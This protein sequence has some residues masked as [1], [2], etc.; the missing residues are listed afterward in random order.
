MGKTINR[1]TKI[2]LSVVMMFSV[3]HLPA[4][5]PTSVYATTDETPETTTI[6][7]ETTVEEQ[8]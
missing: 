3:L 4:L 2:V 1:F 7:T 8:E 6:D 5:D